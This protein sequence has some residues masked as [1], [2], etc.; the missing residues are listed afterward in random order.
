MH[1]VTAPA[2]LE[3]EIR[4][5][6]AAGASPKAIARALGVRPAAVI[7]IVRRAAKEREAAKSRAV[8][9]LKVTLEGTDPPVWR[10]FRV[11]CQ[12]TLADLHLVLQAVMGWE[13]EHLYEFKVGKRRIGE[14]SYDSD[15]GREDAGRI[16]LRDV[17]ARKGARLTYVYDFGDDWQHELIVE[18]TVCPDVEPGKAVCIA[19]ERACPPEDCGG[20][21]GYA[22]LL[23]ALDDPASPEQE[24]RVGWLE[25]VHGAY[26]SEHFE[27]DAVNLW[28]DHLKL[29]RPDRLVR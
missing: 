18:E 7:P 26:D 25:E 16:Q 11:P 3:L 4:A 8:Y 10:R 1:S 14:P 12:I 21:W 24:E 9:Q 29:L 28:L 19:G 20:I 2:D 5:R 17:A 27:L 22:E 15:N 13:N 6:H 23:D